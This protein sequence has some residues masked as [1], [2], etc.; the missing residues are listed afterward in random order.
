VLDVS[1]PAGVGTGSGAKDKR[2]SPAVDPFTDAASAPPELVWHK[3]YEAMQFL[4]DRA[5]DMMT[6]MVH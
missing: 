2:S 5:I 3:N 6:R 4:I 1:P